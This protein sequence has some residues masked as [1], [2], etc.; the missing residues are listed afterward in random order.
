MNDSR[1]PAVAAVA[2]LIIGAGP[3]GMATAACLGRRGVPFRMLDRT[4]VAGGA[5]RAI[6]DGITL[7]S[8]TSFTAL[9]GLPRTESGEYTRVPE[10]RAYLQR[11]AAHHGLAVEQADVRSI[12]RGDSG[13]RVEAGERVWLASAIVVATGMWSWP[14]AP[15]FDGAAA[16]PVI[17]AREWRGPSA[18]D[19]RRVL[20]VGGGTSAI[21]IAEEIARAGRR[22]CVAARGG[23]VKIVPQRFLGL[24]LHHWAKPLELLLPTALA[25]GYCGRRPTL[26]G[27]DLGFAAFRK[28]GRIEVRPEVARIDG[29]EVRFA[30]GSRSGFDLVVTA[31]GY[32]FDTPF[33]PPEVARAPA[34]HLLAHRGES[35]S[36]PGLF[37]IGSPCSVGLDSEFLRG[38]ARDAELVAGRILRRAVPACGG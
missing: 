34:G 13:F 2:A 19:A 38:I 22:V 37:V 8:P 26:P 24:D 32:R 23:R 29:R 28:L 14:I 31:T 17:H 33:L 11:Y 25:R 9:P 20:V 18:V 5:Y 1:D 15:R 36:W 16:M 6:Y 4:G 21:E 3:S 27:T 30:D 7:A 35:V 10:Y 12:A